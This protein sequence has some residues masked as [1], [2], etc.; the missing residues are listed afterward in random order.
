[1]QVFISWNSIQFLHLHFTHVAFGIYITLF[2]LSETLKNVYNKK[3]Y[4]AS[5]TKKIYIFFNEDILNK[6]IG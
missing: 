1:M 3:I 6:D 4:F 5:F 2:F